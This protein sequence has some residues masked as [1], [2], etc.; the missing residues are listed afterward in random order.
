MPQTEE[1]FRAEH[2]E[3]VEELR[4]KNK[5]LESRLQMY[6]R[7]HGKL[8]VFFDEVKEAIT[9]V[10]EYEPVITKDAVKKGT[11]V[12]PA[13]QITDTHN[14]AKQEPD[15]IEGFNAFN[16]DIAHERSIRFAE[17]AVRWVNYQ[18]LAYRI[19]EVTVIFTGD[20]ISGDIHDELRITNAYPTPVQVV[21]SSDDIALQLQII[22]PHF[23]KVTVEFLTEDNHSRLTKK[24]QAKEAGLNSLNYL[25]GYMLKEKISSLSNVVMNIYPMHEK[26]IHVNERQYLICH[27]HDVTSWMGI[28]WYPIERKVGRESQARLQLIMQDIERAKEIGFHKYVFGHWH[29]PFD[30]SLYSCGASLSGTDA[31]DHQAGRYAKPGQTV[32]LVHPKHGEFNRTTFNLL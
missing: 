22:A 12:Q 6:R 11:L 27:G 4:R 15:E 31:Y 24:P 32:W 23:K 14:G 18:K 26:V 29:T 17:K 21:R 25:V 30:I 19:E 3:K 28:P 8:Q 9:P 13:F 1:Q 10:K 5:E 20:L 7:E 2:S 16:P